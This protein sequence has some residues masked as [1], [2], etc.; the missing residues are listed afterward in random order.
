MKQIESGLDG[1]NSGA[2]NVCLPLL[3]W[4]IH[5]SFT[6]NKAYY[7]LDGFLVLCF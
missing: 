1:P 3:F 5:F 6:R 4:A 2:K 7:L